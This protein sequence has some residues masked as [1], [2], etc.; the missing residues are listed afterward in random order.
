MRR[1]PWLIIVPAAALSVGCWGPDSTPTDVKVAVA[2]AAVVL[3]PGG[4]QAFTATVTGSSDGAV[5]WTASCGEVAGSGDAVIYTAPLVAGTCTLTATSVDD[6]AAADTALV[7][8]EAVAPGGVVWLR[9][10]GAGEGTYTGVADVF[11]DAAD[12]VLVAGI[13]NGD[14]AGASAGG[15][16]AF[17]AKFDGDGVEAWRRQFGTGVTDWA[18]A[19]AVDAGGR[20]YVTGYT[21]GDLDGTDAG[22]AF[23]V[24]FDADGEELWRRQFGATRDDY[25]LGVVAD[26]GGSIF[27]TWYAAAFREGVPRAFVSKFDAFGTEVWRRAYGERFPFSAS[28]VDARGRVRVTG[29]DGDAGVFVVIFDAAGS[30]VDRTLI[31]VPDRVENLTVRVDGRLWATGSTLLGE[32]GGV[33]DAFEGFVTA[34]E[35]AGT[36]AWRRQ[37]GLEQSSV[38]PEA[39][40]VNDDGRVLVAGSVEWPGS[41]GGDWTDVLLVSFDATG[42]ELWR[43][44]FAATVRTGAWASDA[45]FDTSGSPVVVGG[46]LGTLEPVSIEPAATVL[47]IDEVVDS[48]AFIL[49]LTP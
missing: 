7:T 13:T 4:T 18:S 25:G 48:E 26:G 31:A 1:L 28:A 30:E 6:A 43:R 22:R 16:D 21:A 19:V 36:V 3:A 47:P 10:I 35:P 11:V 34:F 20:V 46:T 8:V 32:D 40:A 27:V 24:A 44:R 23:L 14:L 5:A 39:V 49:K 12:H 45:A 42:E 37:F 2:P 29:D 38:Q 33:L 17:V 9:Q 41:V 15:A